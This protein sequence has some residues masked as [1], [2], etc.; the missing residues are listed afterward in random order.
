MRSLTEIRVSGYGLQDK[1][2]EADYGFEDIVAQ[3]VTV[4][5]IV[6][7]VEAQPDFAVGILRGESLEGKIDS[8]QR[9]GEHNRCAA[10]R[11]A[12]DEQLRGG[13]GEADFRCFAAMVD[14]GEDGDVLRVKDGFK[15]IKRFGNGVGAG[16]G[17]DAV[18][19]GH[20]EPPFIS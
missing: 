12:K 18:G 15:A 16:V 1:G 6:R 8:G 3:G 10:L 14:A 5:Q 7:I 19:C 20:R 4:L 2:F 9:S 11:V 17:D 13:H